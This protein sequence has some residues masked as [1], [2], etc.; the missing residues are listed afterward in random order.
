MKLQLAL[1]DI[2]LVDALVLVEKIREYIYI[3]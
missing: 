3:I 1:D 2:K